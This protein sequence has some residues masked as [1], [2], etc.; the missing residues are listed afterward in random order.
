M[1]IIIALMFY[2]VVAMSCSHTNRADSS[3]LLYASD[4][5]NLELSDPGAVY[6]HD[7]FLFLIDRKAIND[8]I[9]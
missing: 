9:Q 1:K 7:D 8:Y 3:G 2:V 6:I 5:I 4:T